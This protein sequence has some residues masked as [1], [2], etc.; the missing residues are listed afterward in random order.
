[1]NPGFGGSRLG[2]V[3]CRVLINPELCSLRSGDGEATTPALRPRNLARKKHKKSMALMDV[4][5]VA[6]WAYKP[7]VKPPPEA[8]PTLAADP[9]CPVC[10]LPCDSSDHEYSLV[11]FWCI[12]V[13]HKCFVGAGSS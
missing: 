6:Q 2:W 3:L 10:D 13:Q 12:P 11:R 5:D 8:T 9:L 7:F 1:M 4:A